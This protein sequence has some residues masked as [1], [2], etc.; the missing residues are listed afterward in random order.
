[1]TE[2]AGS[3]IERFRE[4]RVLVHRSGAIRTPHPMSEDTA[5][6]FAAVLGVPFPGDVRTGHLPAARRG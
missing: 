5:R 2:D 3:A 1:V 6:A 4:G